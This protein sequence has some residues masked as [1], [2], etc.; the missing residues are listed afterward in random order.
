VDDIE[1]RLR[2]NQRDAIPRL[3]R[4]ELVKKGQLVATNWKL[5]GEQLTAGLRN[6]TLHEIRARH[7]KQARV[8]A[9][10]L[11]TPMIKRSD[12]VDALRNA[13][14]IKLLLPLLV[15]N[16]VPPP[17]LRLERLHLGP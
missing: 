16:D 4:I 14:G 5:I 12:R 7:V 3:G 15:D 10:R 1:Q 8:G 6:L 9:L 17:D 2:N 11:D 13:R